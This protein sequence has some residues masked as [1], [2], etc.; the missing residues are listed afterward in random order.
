MM[1]P[2]VETLGFVVEL[3]CGKW[4]VDQEKKTILVAFL[5]ISL[6]KADVSTYDA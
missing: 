3:L 6:V 5:Q 2:C 4:K 1:C